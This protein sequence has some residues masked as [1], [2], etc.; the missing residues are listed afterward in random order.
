MNQSLNRQ[1]QFI[2]AQLDD[3]STSHVVG[4]VDHDD[5]SDPLE[6]HTFVFGDVPAL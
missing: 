4:W 2:I 6:C 1:L 5:L 3:L